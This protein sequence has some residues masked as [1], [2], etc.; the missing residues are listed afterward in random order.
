MKSHDQIVD[1]ME[2]ET[3]TTEEYI[4]VTFRALNYGI[5]KVV[6]GITNYEL[7]IELMRKL[8]L[9]FEPAQERAEYILNILLAAGKIKLENHFYSKI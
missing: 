2:N 5:G 8:G 9:D 1:E 4:A 6:H 7:G 3:I